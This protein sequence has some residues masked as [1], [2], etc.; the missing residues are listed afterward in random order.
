MKK[1]VF[2]G[3]SITANFSHLSNHETITNLGIG[4]DKTLELI[5]R[6]KIFATLEV[7]HLF[8]M[9][10]INDFLCNHG[11]WV[12]GP[13]IPFFTMYEALL[14]MLETNIN[15]KNITLISILP[16]IAP[17]TIDI[18]SIKANIE[19]DAI[20]KQI[21]ILAK[22]YGF[23]YLNIAPKFKDLSNQLHE[24]YT[25]DGIH[26][27]ALG[28]DLYYDLIIPYLEEDYDEL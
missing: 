28:Y 20:N 27:N 5:G 15:H 16:V 18:S 25:N 7:D 13:K 9:I 2:Y 24:K 3:D 1:I 23:H 19:I 17:N 10:G 6:S 12:H 26:L 14:Q 8:M 11:A 21:E 22:K 4:G